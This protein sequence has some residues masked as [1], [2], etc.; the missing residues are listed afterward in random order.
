M[1]PQGIGN[2][3]YTALTTAGTTT[4]CQGPSSFGA[5]YP[6]NY[7]DGPGA[8]VGCFYGFTTLAAGTSFAATFYDVVQGLPSG[9]ST[10]TTNTLMNGTGTAGQVLTPGPAG[11]GVRF[12]GSLVVVTSGTPGALNAL[13]D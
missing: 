5:A 4:I 9:P 6:V 2:C 8:A 1:G 7:G 10:L 11:V 3:R 13:W 12:T